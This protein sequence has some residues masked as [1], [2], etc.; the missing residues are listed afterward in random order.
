MD[1]TAI[2]GQADA[3]VLGDLLVRLNGSNQLVFQWDAFDHLPA[4]DDLDPQIDH[5]GSTVDWTHGNAID[6]AADGNYLVSFRNI[7]Q[8]V[9]IDSAS[10]AVLWKLGGS[11]GDFTFV[12]DP[13]GGFSLQHG[14]RELPNGNLLLFDNG[15]GH[16]PPQTRAVEY[17]LDL[18]ARTARMVWQYDA[19]PHLFAPF[20]GFAQRLANNNTLVSYGP[21][22][23]VR[24]VNLAEQLQWS[25]S[26]PPGQPG[27]IYR[28]FRID[29]LY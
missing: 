7:S 24:E 20:T 8:V 17:H 4:I 25:L 18:N 16:N 29:S 2:G 6:V 5:T 27:L 12:D 15:N 3:Q 28:S 22:A 14:I 13:L 9:K 26:G 10:G 11:D 19:N 21:L 23:T 1:L